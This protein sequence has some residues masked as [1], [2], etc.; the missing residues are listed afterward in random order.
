M[1]N[2][3]YNLTNP[4]KSIYYSEQFFKDTS[5]SNISGTVQID[6]K[7]D[8][9]V[10]SQAVN[11]IIKNNIALR[12]KIE[13][14]N[15]EPKQTFSNYEEYKVDLIE[16]KNN[17]ELNILIDKLVKKP[18]LHGK[19]NLFRFTMF[20][21]P[22]GKGGCNI[23]HSHLISDAWSSTLICK[24]L[25]K[26]Y[27]DLL[28]NRNTDKDSYSYIDY[29]E[30]ENNYLNSDR[31]E[32]DKQYW[33]D[34]YKILPELATLY[35]DVDDKL[36]S[37]ANRIE[38]KLSENESN[39]ILEY[40]SKNHVSIFNFMISIYSIYFSRILGLDKITLGT[41]ILNRK[42]I[43]E[44]STLGMYVNTI[45]IDII[46]L[47][48]SSIKDLFEQTAKEVLTILRHQRYPYIEL[49]SY[50]R[51]KFNVSRGLY[52]IIISYQNAK[53]GANDSEIPYS[54]KWDFNGNISETLN[55]HISDIDATNRI[56][57]YYDYQIQKLTENDI[58]NLHKRMLFIINQIISNDNLLVN[59]I[60][61]VTNDEK[62]LIKEINMTEAKYP[63]NKT[64][65][66]IF[67]EQA[68]KTPNRIAVSINNEKITYKEL[69]SRA[70]RLAR[71]LVEKGVTRDVPVGIRINKSLEMIIGILAIIKAGG[72]YLPIN[73]SYPEE[74]VSFM[75]KDSSA[76]LLLT[77]KKSNDLKLDIETINLEN[78]NIYD[79]NDQN[80]KIKNNI[81]D[82]LYIIYTSG[83]TGIPKG[84]MI[85]HRNVVRLM[86][87]DKF[88]FD[89]NEN[90]VWTMFHSVAFDFS[91]WEMYGALLYGGKL[92]LVPEDIAKSPKEFLELLRRE[93]V[94]VLNQT[95]T[96]FYNLLEQEMKNEDTSLKVRYIIFGGEALKPNLIK[97]W[98][99]KYSFTR[100]INMYGIT[101]T[102]V[103]VT[104]KEL[105][106]MDLLSSKSNIGVPIPTLKTYILD[107]KHRLLPIG[108][109][110][111]ICVS[112]DGVCRGYL[113]RPELNNEK[114][115]QN[116]FNKKE[117]LYCSA[118]S[119]ILKED[120]NLYYK[121][122][123]D[124]QVKIRGF[125][126]ELGEIETKLLK[127]P[128]ISK[129][130]VLAKKDSDKDSHLVAYIVCNKDIKIDELKKYMKDLVP[131]YMIPNYFI[132]LK[133]IPINS[134]G[135][136]DRKA[137]STIKYTVERENKYEAPRNEFEE[138]LK[139]IIEE[140]MNITNVGIDDD[141][142]NLGADSLTLMRITAKLLD[143]KYEVSIQKFYEQKTIRKINDTL[144][145]EI[146]E[147]DKLKD[148]VY[149]NFNDKE[150][151]EK[152]KF[153]NVLLTG[154]TGFLGIHILNE[155]IKN[156]KANVYCLIRDKNGI[157]GKERLKEKINFYFG[158]E[159][160][161]EIDKRIYVIKGDISN[162]LLGLDEDE[163]KKLGY[164]IDLVIH[165][166][167]IVNHYG[168]KEIFELINVTGTKNIAEFCKSYNIKLNH[169]S[170]IS[171]SAD[172][173]SNKKISKEFN[174]HTLYIGQPYKKNI[175][176]KTKF[177]AE[178]NLLKEMAKGLE[179]TI[180]RLG[181][182]TSRYCD[183]KFQEND[184]QN[185]FLNRILSFI[186]IGRV[187]NEMLDYEFDMSPVDI[188]SEFIIKILE[189]QSSYGKVFH[190]ANNNKITLKNIIKA[191]NIS[192][193][194]IVTQEEFRNSIKNN[195]EIIGIIND[196]TSNVIFGKNI[197]IN[198]DF[199]QNYLNKLNLNWC[200]INNSYIRKYV[201][202][203][204][205]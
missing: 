2:K 78:D 144:Y 50:I 107:K 25:M 106:E 138:T 35:K 23:V 197:N 66:N 140:E 116:P 161:R 150:P 1:N 37:N 105:S 11:L 101:E 82:L 19:E 171:V 62:K 164:K 146:D 88:L 191:L 65:Y 132:K 33:Q 112:G 7:V 16:V 175:Y 6:K 159:L 152:I 24:Q 89:F 81:D 71:Y 4:Q 200:N 203:Y 17:K 165:S 205:E 179:V 40:C 177:E 181:N 123:I 174:E 154:A 133:E 3:M 135:K 117:R 158:K 52:D 102:T 115:I 185:A 39:K 127:H 44:K 75:L 51:E 32:K 99:D 48:N 190:I 196:I 157:N 98:K 54:A 136:A 80:L 192:N 22:N 14:I 57:I 76:K 145:Q 139:K 93:K 79:F 180:F 182:I 186:K 142:L 42:N 156:T 94:T 9:E 143:Q 110:G 49:L 204:I 109:E 5:I 67:E 63:E 30:E 169:I 121:G 130:V 83:S 129:C 20:K 114:F 85:T 122:R 147:N 126:V 163:Y 27:L 69:N 128:S 118:D 53:T 96:F 141:I 70:N 168:K 92:V 21:F 176:V 77:N 97:K 72:C 137:L 187:T 95:P 59:D 149:Y 188:C 173:V 178:Y 195:K 199:T 73:L 36:N 155:L 170:T 58:N 10:L 12:T 124:N 18:F 153:S 108:I 183:G 91:V 111:E 87:N 184:Y 34:K 8:F 61:I 162:N 74:R 55:I 103:H 68:E 45:P 60:D 38:C 194:K 28:N 193:I 86:K 47:E 15:N 104:F 125:R 90:D 84:A 202:K 26:N 119:A 160:L 41:P 56:N 29:I 46:L 113:N 148:D 43:K 120:G 100:L 31:F 166:A 13:I 151:S 172:F 134:N 201:K 131:T 198:S 64:V 189:Y 167:A